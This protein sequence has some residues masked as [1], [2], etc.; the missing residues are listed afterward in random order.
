[1]LNLKYILDFLFDI[2][3]FIGRVTT[4]RKKMIPDY[5]KYKINE[6]IHNNRKKDENWHNIDIK[7]DGYN[8]SGPSKQKQN[9]TF[10]DSCRN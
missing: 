2:T 8:I 10:K 7:H 3:W 1:M 9:K 6:P 5:S 4:H